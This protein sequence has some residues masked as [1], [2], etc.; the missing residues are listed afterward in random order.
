MILEKCHFFNSFF[1]KRLLH[2]IG[3]TR[4]PSEQDRRDGYKLVRRWAKVNL[5]EK[6]YIFVPINESLHWSLA[7]ICRPGAFIEEQL[8]QQAASAPPAGP[9]SEALSQMAAGP[10][11]SDDEDTEVDEDNDGSPAG[12]ELS[13]AAP[14]PADAVEDE[15]A[16]PL[17]KKARVF[18]RQ[19]GERDVAEGVASLPSALSNVLLNVP[20]SP[21][22]ERRALARAGT[23]PPAS[24]GYASDT[25][26]G[27]DLDHGLR[28]TIEGGGPG[29][30]FDFDSH[31]CGGDEF[32]FSEESGAPRHHAQRRRPSP[33]RKKRSNESLGGTSADHGRA[34][35]R[36]GF[37]ES[38]DFVDNLQPTSKRQAL[39]TPVRGGR[40]QPER[41][42]LSEEAPEIIATQHQRASNPKGAGVDL[43]PGLRASAPPAASPHLSPTRVC[44]SASVD[45]T[46]RSLP[47]NASAHAGAASS[48]QQPGLR[49]HDE[50]SPSVAHAPLRP[51]QPAEASGSGSSQGDETDPICIDARRLAEGDAER[52][53]TEPLDDDA[54]PTHWLAG[55]DPASSCE[56]APSLHAP[57]ALVDLAADVLPASPTPPSSCI[58]YIDSLSSSREDGINILKYYLEEEWKSKVRTAATFLEDP[59]FRNMPTK[60]VRVTQQ[61]NHSDCGLYM[62]KYIE[63]FSLYGSMLEPPLEGQPGKPKWNDYEKLQFGKAE[64]EQMRKQMHKDIEQLGKEQR[65]T[66][67]EHKR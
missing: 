17:E 9:F 51:C 2:T 14:G 55:C 38:F 44:V 5:F 7:I 43:C 32:T 1:Y 39:S 37:E 52:A 12:E 18:R 35:A 10:R 20:T 16:A 65:G 58:L 25:E 23:L 57:R 21:E 61:H 46:G 40:A 19:M 63:K 15:D 56:P 54:S 11:V 34:T 27:D 31:V 4:N 24:S 53:R 8:K 22:P 42:D 47:G 36:H 29:G 41:V 26:E 28:G 62:L 30:A 6:D 48:R 13:R 50:T 49:E 59:Q 33:G 64:I 3:R 66:E 45:I 67:A 60:Q